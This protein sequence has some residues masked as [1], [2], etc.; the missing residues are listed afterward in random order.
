MY[1]DINRGVLEEHPSLPADC[2]VSPNALDNL[3]PSAPL[4]QWSRGFMAGHDWLGEL[5]DVEM[6]EDMDH[7]VGASVMTLSFFASKKLARS[8]HREVALS[9]GSLG[10]F[11]SEV[12]T[13]LPDALVEY[14]YI[15]R[16]ILA[17]AYAAASVQKPRRVAQVG[18]NEPCP[19]RSGKKSKKCCGADVR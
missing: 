15:G 10:T 7:E 14:A 17:E 12:L 4:S 1:N 3:D 11:A 2:V 16:T 19:C 13:L 8:Y 6:P 5:W 9:S 18:R